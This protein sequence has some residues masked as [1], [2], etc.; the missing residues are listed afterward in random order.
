MIE[1]LDLSAPIVSGR[2]LAGLK[3]GARLTKYRDLLNAARDQY[4]DFE[5]GGR[6]DWCHFWMEPWAI[7]YRL[8]QVLDQTDEEFVAMADAVGRGDWDEAERHLAYPEED[9]KPTV[10]VYADVRVAR[11]FMLAALPGY[12]GTARGVSPG[13]TVA[14]AMAADSRVRYDELLDELR[15]DDE[16]GIGFRLSEVDPPREAVPDLVIEAVE[17]YAP[18]LTTRGGL[19]F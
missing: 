7:R 18:K 2:G 14:Q 3:V 12:D 19:T 11:V 1:L 4:G 15:V 13:M 10:E 5:D 16:E 6:S 8:G 9:F 17:V